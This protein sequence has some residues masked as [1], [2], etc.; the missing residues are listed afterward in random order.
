MLSILVLF[1]EQ[2]SR[3]KSLVLHLVRPGDVLA[4][5]HR[6]LHQ[7]LNTCRRLTA[8]THTKKFP[9]TY[10]YLAVNRAQHSAAH[11]CVSLG[12]L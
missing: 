5:C 11:D 9:E 12:R 3:L 1:W 6:V 8:S 7:S 4:Q 2:A 10:K